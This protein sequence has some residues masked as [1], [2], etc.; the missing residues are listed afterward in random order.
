MVAESARMSRILPW[1]R[2]AATVAVAVPSIGIAAL[3]FREVILEP[4]ADSLNTGFH[5]AL[6]ATL[7]LL[8]VDFLTAIRRTRGVGISLA[9]GLG[10][11]VCC[12]AGA[13]LSEMFGPVAL[14]LLLA[15]TAAWG[16]VLV[17]SGSGERAEEALPD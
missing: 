14:A 5:V 10:G 7:V 15:G 17:R 6:G 4:G 8:F 16:I 9:L 12:L 1:A 13:I 3:V 11:L 2:A